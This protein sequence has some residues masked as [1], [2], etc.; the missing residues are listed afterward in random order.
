MIDIDFKFVDIENSLPALES[1]HSVD[2]M[3]TAEMAVA[4]LEEIN[5]NLQFLNTLL[6]VFICVLFT[7]LGLRLLYEVLKIFI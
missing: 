7:V 4:L 6:F 2:D 3:A 1:I 5:A